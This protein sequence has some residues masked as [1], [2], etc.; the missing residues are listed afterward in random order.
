MIYLN[1]DGVL[2]NDIS[3]LTPFNSGFLDLSSKAHVYLNEHV[4]FLPGVTVKSVISLV[5]RNPILQNILSNYDVKGFLNVK[6]QELKETPMA[7]EFLKIYYSAEFNQYA[8]IVDVA[9]TPFILGYRKDGEKSVAF[10]LDFVS[11]ENLM[12]VPLVLDPLVVAQGE[13]LLNSSNEQSDL[14]FNMPNFTLLAILEAVFTEL[15][16]YDEGESAIDS[17]EFDLLN[18]DVLPL[19]V[20]AKELILNLFDDGIHKEVLFTSEF[21]GN[22]KLVFAL[23]EAMPSHVNVSTLLKEIFGDKVYV[24]SNMINCNAYEFKLRAYGLS[25]DKLPCDKTKMH[26]S[27]GCTI[28]SDVKE[29]SAVFWELINSINSDVKKDKLNALL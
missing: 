26:K 28:R 10:G 27:L 25:K 29:F 1:K 20:N 14:I 5:E 22:K 23:I 16:P 7:F 17:K 21:R 15:N 19:E 13:C 18:E 11:L 24:K 4:K 2:L 12:D 8:N 3:N 9:S 6:N